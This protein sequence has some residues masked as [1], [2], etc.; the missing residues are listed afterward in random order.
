S[1]LVT[2]VA[3]ASS[4]FPGSSPTPNING[5][6]TDLAALLAFKAQL[7]D[8]LGILARSWTTNVSFC[9]W[10][11]VSCS[12]RQQR[13][14][15]LSLPDV[16]LKG[17]LTPHLGNLSFLMLLNLT[18]TGLSGAIPADLGRLS[19]LRKLDLGRNGLSGSI[20]ST[21]FNMSLLQVMSLGRNNLTGS[22][23][24]NQNF[25]LPVLRKL[26]LEHNN[27]EGPIPQE[28]SA[29]Q[30][31]QYLSLAHNSFCD[32]V[33]T[34]LAELSQLKTIFLGRNHLVGSIP[35][36]LSNLTGLT[37]LDLSFCNLTGDIPTELGLMREL[38]YLHLGNNQLAGPIPTSL[39]NLSKMSDLILQKNQL[40]GSVPATLGNIRA[41][42]NL[43]LQLNNLNGDLDFLSSLSNCRQLQVL[44]IS[45][46]S[47]SGGLPDHF[48]ADHNKIT[49]V[50]P[51][52]LA[53]LSGLDSLDLSK[54]LLTGA[55]P[56]SITSMKNLV[57]L[58]VSG[59]DMSG[60]IPTQIG[61]MK[62]LQRLY[63][64]G[65]KFFG[66]IPNSIG[67]LT[68]LE[69]LVMRNNH[70]NSTIPASLFHLDKLIELSLSHNYFSG[71]LPADV[72]GLKLADQI[73]I[74]SNML[75]GKIPESFGQLRML[76]QLDLSHNSF[77]GT[78]PESFQEL[79]SLELLDIS[80]NNLSGAIPKFLA[81]FTSLTTLNLS[82]NKLEGKIPEGGIF[83]NITLTSLIGNAGLCGSPRLGFSP[84]LEKSDSTDRHLLKLLL[85]AATIAFV[86]IV[87][88]VYLM[89]KR[90]LKN[91][92]VHASV[93]G[94]SDVMRHRLIS[95][96]ELVR[97]TDNFSDNNLLGT[98]SFGKVFKGQLNTGLVVA[99]KVLDMQKEQAIRSFDAEC[100][101]LR[102]ARHRNLI[103]ILNTC[104]N[105]DLRILVLEY[106]P[107]GSLDTLLH[108]E[109]R[110]HLGFL[111]RLDIM[112]DV[113][114]A[115][116]YLHHEHHEVVLHCDLK[117]TNVLFDDDMTAH[118]AD[119][120]IAKFLLGDDNSMITTTMP[121]TLGYMAPE[122]G[123]LGKASRKSD[124]FSYGIMLLEVFTGKRPTDLMFDGELS[125][126][127]WVHQAFPSELA[128]VLDDQLLQE[129]S[130]TC[131][132]N[133]S[134]LPILELGL[135]CSSDSPEQRMSMSSVV[136]K[137][138]KIKKDHEK[139]H[140]QQ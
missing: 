61:M 52:T 64:R 47:F 129:A 78:I 123:S 33:P 138:K 139:R 81:N 126:R 84:C 34:W 25:S 44:A 10:F 86:S 76:A 12:R 51:S 132:L 107:N 133:D 108:S 74:S 36:V 104:S 5:S 92:R 48:Y 17:E 134:L 83:S 121:G 56:E 122:Y 127:Q 53:K 97:A 98:G 32:T 62:S 124:V 110:R 22:I 40:S 27:F 137:L 91:K 94:L 55:I 119:F 99:I 11:R 54:N 13:V 68:N 135:L 79:T 109:G 114:M 1:V 66:S 20:P 42:K 125:I 105:L 50:L 106:M 140:Q 69:Y 89:I 28:L 80:S 72:S 77:Q 30:H 45:S 117:P 41:L 116:E 88:C 103:K 16:S 38:S 31:L 85:P 43:K 26:N 96:H 15:A 3:S 59:N 102:M 95:Y 111:K 2:G 118:V 101:A 71:A 112:L 65:N 57:Y 63:L 29:C 70:F 21:M 18:N 58:D 67:N 100:R 75:T 93:A 49:G 90:K 87:L 115:M 46:N 113:S 130:S 120:G 136:S 24:S 82:F 39:T 19:R 9:G 131:N 6:E 7:S 37:K 4:S 60:P 14:I 35:A 8:P 73:Y 128:S 23:P